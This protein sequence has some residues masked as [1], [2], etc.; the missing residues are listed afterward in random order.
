MA[1]PLGLNFP[2][3]RSSLWGSDFWLLGEGVAF[4]ELHLFDCD[5]EGFERFVEFFF[6]EEIFGC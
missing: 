4:D 1:A 5:L 6:I 2:G 3:V